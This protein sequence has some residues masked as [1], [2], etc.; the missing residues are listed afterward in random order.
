MSK[1]ST[2]FLVINKYTEKQLGYRG[3]EQYFNPFGF[4]ALHVFF[5]FPNLS[6]YKI[7]IILHIIL[8][9]LTVLAVTD[10]AHNPDFTRK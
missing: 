7:I 6:R 8:L 10:T 3:T 9:L 4:L 5:F 2:S 1:T